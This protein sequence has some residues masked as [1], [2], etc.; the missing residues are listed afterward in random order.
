MK[1]TFLVNHDIAALLALNYL[2]PSL[3]QHS[4]QVLY[5]NKSG[6]NQNLPKALACLKRFDAKLVAQST[7]LTSFAELGARQA[8]DVNKGDF[9]LLESHRPNLI[10]SIRYM[11]ILQQD[12]IDLA[13][14]GVI[15]LHSGVL[16]NYQG[17]MASFWAMLHGQPQLATSLHRIDDAKIDS[18]QI[19][20]RS[21]VQTNYEKSYLWNV[22]NLYRGGCET[23]IAAIESLSK[24]GAIEA[25][26]Q[27]GQPRYFS[28]PK[29]TDIDQATFKLFSSSDSATSF[30]V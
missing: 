27:T 14:D 21:T 20:A 16:P 19:I 28:F 22:L 23:V 3:T 17:V 24:Y 13:S 7:G 12:C 29:Q 5:S 30:A 26:A 25:T 1:I 10:V 2:I 4:I 9:Q 15:N 8:N 11:T 18:G 6:D